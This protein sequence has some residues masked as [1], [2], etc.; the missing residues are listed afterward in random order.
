M[1]EPNTSKSEPKEWVKSAEDY[2]KKLCEEDEVLINLLSL[3][4]EF[5]DRPFGEWL[6]EELS[7]MAGSMSTWLVNLNQ[8]V[9]RYVGLTNANY[10][11]KKQ[12]RSEAYSR[13]KSQF[14]TIKD[15]EMAADNDILEEAKAHVMAQVIADNL[16]GLSD[17]LTTLVTTMQTRLKHIESDRVRSN[18]DDSV[19]Y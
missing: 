19:N 10:V 13:L 14:D 12:R 15:T 17:T 4:Q 1:Q 11:W 16:K 7:E 3:H 6:P 8:I 2:Y 18:T 9:T 5:I